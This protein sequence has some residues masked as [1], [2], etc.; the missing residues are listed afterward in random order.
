MK[1]LEGA[2]VAAWGQGAYAAW[3]SPLVQSSVSPQKIKSKN[4]NKVKTCELK[5]RATLQL[6]YS[7]IKSGEIS[8]WNMCNETKMSAISLYPKR[9]YQGS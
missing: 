7:M 2:E 3:V 6:S 4:K 5:I 8:I 9:I 1:T